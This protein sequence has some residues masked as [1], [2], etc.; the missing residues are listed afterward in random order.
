MMDFDLP[1]QWLEKR[2]AF[3]ARPYE[4]R[5]AMI[6]ERAEENTKSSSGRTHS[7]QR[8]N[9]EAYSGS[10]AAVRPGWHTAPLHQA[11]SLVSQERRDTM[12]RSRS[13]YVILAI[14]LIQGGCAGLPTTQTV[15]VT[16][17]GFAPVPFVVASCDTG[18]M[19]LLSTEQPEAV[20]V[21]PSYKADT[22]LYKTGH[23]IRE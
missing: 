20:I 18:A 13:Q 9:L 7:R 5:V 6:E 14:V 19:V 17:D 22:Q 2:E 4:T 11:C 21:E 15:S 12:S 10:R 16:D 3:F 8:A 23:N 1:S